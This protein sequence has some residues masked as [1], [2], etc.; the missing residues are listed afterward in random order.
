MVWMLLALAASGADEAVVR[1]SDVVFMGAKEGTVYDA[2]GATMVSWGG[3]AANDSEQAVAQFAA[4]VQAAHDRGMRYCAGLAFRTA[5]A[6]MIDFDPDFM[7]SV[8]RTLDGEPILVP[9]LWDHKHKGH[10][11]YWFCTNAPGYRAFLRD[12]ARRAMLARVEGLHIDDYAGTAGTDWR[13]GCFCPHCMAAFAT[14]LAEHVP[15]ERLRGYGIESLDGFDYGAFLKARGVDVERFR[16][17][18]AGDLPLGP[19][20]L[21]FQYQS[22]AAFVGE[23]RAYAEQLAGRPLMLSV[24][25]SAANARALVI[26]PQLNYFCGEVGHAAERGQV[27]WGPVFVF[28]L[29]DAVGRP[30]VCT[31]AGQDWAYVDEHKV[32]GLV[33]TW[34]A[35][36]YA[37]GH[38]MMCPHRQWA[39]TEQ[40]G[41]HWYQSDPSDYA[42]LYR[43]VRAHAELLDDYEPVALAA[44]VFSTAAG[45][46]EQDAARALARGL[47]ERNI[48]YRVVIASD[49]WLPYRL[50]D[51]SLAGVQAVLTAPPLRLDAAQQA[52]LE[53]ARDRVIEGDDAAALDRLVGAPIRVDG[54]EQVS[55]WPRVVPGHPERPMVV[56]LLNRRYE[57][58]RDVMAPTG[59]FT[60]TLD[61]RLAPDSVSAVRLVAPDREPLELR[62]TT[63]PEGLSIQVPDLDLWALLVIER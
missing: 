59:P 6:R 32:P 36:S 31:A 15:A 42:P 23:I 27:P 12:Q 48:P 47:G 37:L 61:R 53:A 11:A 63:S 39:Y 40:K 7:A 9:W 60:L 62:H 19:E 4:R 34:I 51:E 58:E 55:V 56:H 35:Q 16:R 33:R 43:F 25:S 14:W 26:A 5:F 49:E 45:S 3:Q 54:A 50:T 2:Y 22:S 44:V 46:K 18:V 1:R 38:Q 24:N 10:P 13:G 57:R 30:M 28:K 17:T 29:C 21:R 20:Y 8:C 52:V 41:T